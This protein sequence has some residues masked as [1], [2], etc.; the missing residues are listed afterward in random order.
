MSAVAG[1]FVWL[2]LT[3]WLGEATWEAEWELFEKVAYE[4]HVVLTPGRDC[5][6]KEP[7]YFR[8]CFASLPVESLKIGVAR[9]EKVLDRIKNSSS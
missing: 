2:D 9:M 1:M 8:L 6:A 5:H 7:G 3:A 4:G